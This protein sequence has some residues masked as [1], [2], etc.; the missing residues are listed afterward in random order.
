MAIKPKKRDR[1]SSLKNFFSSPVMKPDSRVIK[2]SG[3]G[4]QL[5]A[6]ILIF[7]FIGIFIDRK[8][9]TEFIFT[10]I[11]TFLGFLGGFYKFYLT[12]K[13]LDKKDKD[14]IE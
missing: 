14:K 3:I 9:G 2:Y 13:E 12:V 1:Y 8:L 10:L 5:A 6:T 7:L 4:V 11:F